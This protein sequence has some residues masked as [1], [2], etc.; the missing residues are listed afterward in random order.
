MWAEIPMLRMRSMFCAT[1][2][3]V[4]SAERAVQLPCFGVKKQASPGLQPP[5]VQ[6]REISRQNLM[7]GGAFRCL[8]HR[9]ALTQSHAV[10]VTGF[11]A[12]QVG[13]GRAVRRAPGGAGGAAA[14]LGV[15][16]GRGLAGGF[17]EDLAGRPA[18]AFDV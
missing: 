14:V 15:E 3:A 4:L 6:P 9:S 12:R 13:V 2:L 11:L 16:G 5:H 8:K 18:R 17:Q 1:S 10:S 7:H